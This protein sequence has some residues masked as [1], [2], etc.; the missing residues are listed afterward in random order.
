MERNCKMNGTENFI[1]PGDVISDPEHRTTLWKVLEIKENQ[2]RIVR[3]GKS[4]Q[5]HGLVKDKS[6]I[7]KPLAD[8]SGFQVIGKSSETRTKRKYTKQ[9]DKKMAPKGA[10]R[11]RPLG[12]PNKPKV[13]GSSEVYRLMEKFHASMAE[14]FKE[15]AGK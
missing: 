14:G 11:G 4:G 7:I 5:I 2:A 10:G 12:I 1:T 6:G 3:S 9:V 15:L 13:T 8:L